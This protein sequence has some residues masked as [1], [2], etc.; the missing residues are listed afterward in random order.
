VRSF[1]VLVVDD[2]RAARAAAVAAL[3]G[4]GY[5]VLAARNAG[6]AMGLLERHP[7]IDLVLTEVVLPGIGG[8]ML[9]DMARVR[10]PDMRVIY[11]SGYAEIAGLKVERLVGCFVAKPVER[12]VLCDAVGQAL[13]AGLPE[14]HAPRPVPRAAMGYRR[15]PS[16]GF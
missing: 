14:P 11:T 9:A 6:D 12:A 5:R 2:D 8:F 7:G 1:L 4:D 15:S 10:R 3:E 16:L 13:R